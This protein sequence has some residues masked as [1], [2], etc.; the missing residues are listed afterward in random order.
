MRPYSSSRQ[1]QCLRPHFWAPQKCYHP[2]RYTFM[3]ATMPCPSAKEYM[4]KDLTL[5]PAKRR[6]PYLLLL[7]LPATSPSGM[8]LDTMATLLQ[9]MPD[10]LAQTDGRA[11]TWEARKATPSIHTHEDKGVHSSSNPRS[12]GMGGGGN[13]CKQHVR[14]S[15]RAQTVGEEQNLR[16]RIEIR[17]HLLRPPPRKVVSSQCNCYCYP[18]KEGT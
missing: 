17:W 5:S 9:S 12:G 3:E 15:G 14:S 8:L 6:T 16:N 4:L 1:R 11:L 2:L 13:E 18:K 7:L 10:T